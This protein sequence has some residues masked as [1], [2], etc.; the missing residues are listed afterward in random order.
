MSNKN[1]R[2]RGAYRQLERE[3]QENATIRMLAPDLPPLRVQI[4][5]VAEGAD[6]DD[7]RS[8]AGAF[9]LRVLARRL[10]H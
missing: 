1:P 3:I 9:A 5:K 2:E 8:Q 7:P 10:P 4:T 6:E